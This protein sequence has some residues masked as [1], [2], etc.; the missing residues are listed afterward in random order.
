MAKKRN[1][2]SASVFERSGIRAIRARAIEVLLYMYL[3]TVWWGDVD[4][5]S[6][7][8]LNYRVYEDKLELKKIFCRHILLS[9]FV[10]FV[11][12]TSNCLHWKWWN[13]MSILTE[14]DIHDFVV[15]V[16]NRNWWWTESLMIL[17]N[18]D[19]K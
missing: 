16:I 2:E 19:R 3:M 13:D 18:S 15:Y 8:C 1:I 4:D 14:W 5:T 12:W 6:S 17:L 10:N 11:V 9:H 7:E